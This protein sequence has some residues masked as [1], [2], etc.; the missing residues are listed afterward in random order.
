VLYLNDPVKTGAFPATGG[1]LAM[2]QLYA[3]VRGAPLGV[4]ASADAA[5]ARSGA[6]AAASQQSR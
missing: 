6:G 5:R 3:R 2:E 4:A 1:M